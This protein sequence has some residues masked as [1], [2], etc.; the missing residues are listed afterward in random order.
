MGQRRRLGSRAL[1][2]V[3]KSIFGPKGW[4][5]LNGLQSNSFAL[6]PPCVVAEALFLNPEGFDTSALVFGTD[7]AG[8][9]FSADPRLRD[10]AWAVVA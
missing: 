1:P 9:P 10:C 2:S 5:V 8:G 3:I 7:G 6:T 4:S